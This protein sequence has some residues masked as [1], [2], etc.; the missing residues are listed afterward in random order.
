MLSRFCTW[1]VRGY[2]RYISPLTP[3]TCRFQPTCSQYAITAYRRFG[4]FR[5]SFLT[6]KR[7]CK[8]H[9]LHSGGYD[10]VEAKNERS[11]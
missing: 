3:P 7:V 2:Q 4:F 1:L 10:P 5:G 9:P 6:L 11:G 8:C